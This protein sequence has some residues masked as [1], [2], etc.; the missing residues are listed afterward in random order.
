MTRKEKRGGGA[1]DETG[2]YIRS[3]LKGG[4]SGGLPPSLAF[5]KLNTNRE[6]RMS[7]HKSEHKKSLESDDWKW[8][9]AE[10]AWTD[11][12]VLWPF[13]HP[14][15]KGSDLLRCDLPRAMT[16]PKSILLEAMKKSQSHLKSLD[17]S[18]AELGAWPMFAMINNYSTSL[19]R[20]RYGPDEP[21]TANHDDRLLD[22]ARVDMLITQFAFK[23]DETTLHAALICLHRFDS[24]V[25]TLLARKHKCKL[26]PRTALMI[27]TW[28]KYQEKRLD[29]FMSHLPEQWLR[30][31]IDLALRATIWI[32]GSP[33]LMDNWLD[34]KNKTVASIATIFYA[35]EYKPRAMITSYRYRLNRVELL[36]TNAPVDYKVGYMFLMRLV[37]IE[38]TLT[39]SY[40]AGTSRIRDD[41]YSE[42]ALEAIVHG[43]Q[44]LY[45][46]LVL[47]GYHTPGEMD[48]FNAER[49]DRMDILRSL[50]I[51]KDDRLD[52]AKWVL[53]FHECIKQPSRIPITISATTK[54][55]RELL[56]SPFRYGVDLALV[57]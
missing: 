32:H 23:V 47:S 45:N 54:R 41:L 36:V 4:G 26:N 9:M 18:L 51:L 24:T 21:T 14:L 42:I 8:D 56:F 25:A 2:N 3:T 39:I 27:M 1:D 10:T 12:D 33:I 22:A 31:N 20:K 29:W 13:G 55:R 16:Q 19:P 38:A 17:M 44:E 57:S 49:V 40:L 6:S 11:P 46:S 43:K 53:E 5:S 37:A 48:V 15:A 50:L 30:D 35:P 28:L 7:K 34:N 52:G